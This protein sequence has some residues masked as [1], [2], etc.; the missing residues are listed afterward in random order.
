MDRSLVSSFLLAAGIATG[1][2]LVGQ[3]FARGR[4]AEHVVTVKGISER[5]VT[6]DLA[7]WP[8]RISAASNDLSAANAQIQQSI[9]QIRQF[10]TRYKIDPSQASL[11]D[12]SVTDAATNQFSTQRAESRYVIHQTVVVRS[13]QPERVLDASQH[14]AE[15]VNAGVVLS[16]GGEYGSGGPTFIFSGLSKLKP[17]MIAEATARAREGAEQFA[18][19][20]HSRIGGIKDANQ[21]V[22]EILPRDQ[23]RGITEASQ[24]QKTVRVVSTVQYFLRE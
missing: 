10:L 24:I 15:L 3:G 7:I 9:Q 16:S 22:F 18:R 2:F 23:A 21:G 12:F 14:V 20:S 1:G 11:Q 6:A 17:E 13:E 4:A 5:N 19:D 8:L